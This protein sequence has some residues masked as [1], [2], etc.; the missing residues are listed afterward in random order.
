MILFCTEEIITFVY[1]SR[2]MEVKLIHTE[3]GGDIKFSPIGDLVAAANKLEN[4]LK[5]IHVS[6]LQE[7]LNAKVS[8]PSNIAWH[9]SMP[10]VCIGDDYKLCFW[11]VATK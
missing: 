4:S 10:L 1:F 2:P 5:V 11:K 7:R 3:A 8:L 6:T 9:S